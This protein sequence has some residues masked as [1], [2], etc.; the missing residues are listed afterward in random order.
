[1]IDAK[2]ITTPLATT[3]TLDLHSG[4]T[5]LDPSEYQTI[6]DN[7]QYLSLTRLDIAYMVNKLSQFMHRP[8]SDHW[9]AVK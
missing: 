3:T 2:P 8:T 6:V 1:M 7:L 4:T 5:I 9:H